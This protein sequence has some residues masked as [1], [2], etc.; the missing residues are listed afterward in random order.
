M[1]EYTRNLRARGIKHGSL[2]FHLFFIWRISGS[3][4]PRALAFAVPAALMAVFLRLEYVQDSDFLRYLGLDYAADFNPALYS[5]FSS[6][7]GFLLV[8]RT[9]QAMDRFKDGLE[10]IFRMSAQWQ[11]AC[12]S[13]IAFSAS[14]DRPA[15]EIRDFQEIMVR[16]FS[17]MHGS[18]LHNISDQSL[19]TIEI[20][21]PEGLDA[22]SL[23]FLEESEEHGHDRVK[24]F[25]MWIERTIVEALRTGV[26]NIPPP[27]LS[28][29]FHEVA[30]GMQEL[31]GAEKIAQVPFP[32]PYAQMTVVLTMLH[33]L[34]TPC[35]CSAIAVNP[36]WA[37]IF[38]F[39]MVLSV[40]SINFIASEIE[41]PFQDDAN[42][43][44]TDEIQK[45]LNSNLVLLLDARMQKAPHRVHH[46]NS[47][48]M[49][50]STTKHF[51]SRKSTKQDGP[52]S[53]GSM[54]SKSLNP[55]QSGSSR[56]GSVSSVGALKGVQLQ[57]FPCQVLDISGQV[58]SC[59]TS[60]DPPADIELHQ[61]GVHPMG[62]RPESA[63]ESPEITA[64]SKPCLSQ[65]PADSLLLSVAQSLQMSQPAT[66][67]TFDP[68][69]DYDLSTMSA[70][71]QSIDL[72]I[73]GGMGSSENSPIRPGGPPEVQSAHIPSDVRNKGGA[74]ISQDG[75]KSNSTNVDSV[76]IHHLR[77]NVSDAR[78]SDLPTGCS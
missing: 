11:E 49:L 62:H 54:S 33:W 58:R 27:I 26:L 73:I 51:V 60:D 76:G 19:E 30:D 2:T 23:A 66:A 21:D 36:F 50:R 4:F 32:F 68:D 9:S 34:I 14:S 48:P 25:H 67:A 10:S 53:P 64:S 75:G 70:V 18:G 65:T 39:I 44:P 52:L 29:V 74:A 45:H 38:S 24:V 46:D 78:A 7:L 69:V 13:L 43:L 16:L 61:D 12:S 28:R 59:P 15:E 63:F 17:M 55:D 1:I 47:K 6:I 37:G 42:D 8:F 72:K 5:S 40:W 57:S 77:P 3:V 22:D 41:Q 56:S 31:Q 35:I 71:I 20:L